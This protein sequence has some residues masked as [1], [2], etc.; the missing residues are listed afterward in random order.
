[1]LTAFT[2]RG[3]WLCA[4]AVALWPPIIVWPGFFKTPRR[5]SIKYI[6]DLP[7]TNPTATSTDLATGA[8]AR[9]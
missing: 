3:S 2:G 1:M 6:N 9:E 8:A 5:L 4:S 7:N